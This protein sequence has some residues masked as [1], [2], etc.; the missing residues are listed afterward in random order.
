MS[1]NWNHTFCKTDKD[2]CKN[3]AD[4]YY[5]FSL[6]YSSNS[7]IRKSYKPEMS[8][9]EDDVHETNGSA[10]RQ[11]KS[12][13][14]YLQNISSEDA[15]R[16]NTANRKSVMRKPIA[17][18]ASSEVIER[19][20]PTKR[21]PSFETSSSVSSSSKGSFREPKFK[22]VLQ[23]NNSVT[24]SKS[25]RDGAFTRMKATK[26]MTSIVEEKLED[27]ES[28]PVHEKA[29]RTNSPKFTENQ[30][31]LCKRGANDSLCEATIVG[32]SYN[33]K[34]QPVYAIHYEGYDTD[35]NELISH[36]EAAK[37]F[38]PTMTKTQPEI[39]KESTSKNVAEVNNKEDTVASLSLPIVNIFS[40]EAP[41]F[42]ERL[43]PFGCPEQSIIDKFTSPGNASDCVLHFSED[44]LHINK[45][46]LS[47]YSHVFNAAFNQEKNQSNFKLNNVGVGE[48]VQLLDAIYPSMH[49]GV[50]KE[51]NIDSLLKLCYQ[52]EIDDILQRCERF[53]L[54]CRTVSIGKKLLVAQEY[55]LSALMDKCASQ[56]KSISDYKALKAENGYE[57]LSADT[58]AMLGSYIAD[59]EQEKKPA[60]T[61]IQKTK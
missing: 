15:T 13:L 58:K 39:N 32:I 22:K 33:Q 49:R 24:P 3:I 56:F 10:N 16:K 36:D 51:E 9:K 23:C 47:V 61:F 50:V 60:K 38:K 35:D 46:L 2:Y 8:Q 43:F 20:L 41:T 28:S 7:L 52:F 18:G 54:D 42:K 48:F 1:G 37:R 57:S 45:G 31:I 59:A 25:M 14:S 12:L 4:V 19:V 34:R 17:V 29:V 26:K 6:E 44:R 11:P 5:T 53:L 30:K 21:K 55:R 40:R 27:V